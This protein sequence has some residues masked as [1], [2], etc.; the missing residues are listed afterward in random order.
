MG[1]KEKVWWSRCSRTSGSFFLEGLASPTCTPLFL[2]YFTGPRS[3][4]AVR[5][6]DLK[7][8]ASL[9]MLNDC[10]A[11]K[12]YIKRYVPTQADVAGFEAV[13]RP[14]PAALCHALRWNNHIRSYEKEKA[15]LLGVKGALGQHGLA[16]EQDAPES[17]A[18]GS[19]ADY[20]TISLHLMRRRKMKKPRG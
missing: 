17:G 15:S 3:A 2:R 18:A 19:K 13:S 5:S 16:D 1:A 10:L 14:P 7:S 9:Q 4:I 20:A 12:S 11:D 8:L 6:G